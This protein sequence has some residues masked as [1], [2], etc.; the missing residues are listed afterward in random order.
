MHLKRQRR[1]K[2]L[3]PLSFVHG[4]TKQPVFTNIFT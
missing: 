3:L 2:F 4:I 1:Q